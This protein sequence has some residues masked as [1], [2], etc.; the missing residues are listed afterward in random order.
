MPGAT[1]RTSVRATRAV[2]LFAA[3]V[4]APAG[5]EMAGPVKRRKIP[6]RGV[7]DEHHIP[8]A[9]A[10]AAIGPAARDVGL[11]AKAHAAVPAAPPLDLNLCLVV[12][13]RGELTDHWVGWA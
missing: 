13:H 6:A 3:P 1:S 10:V 7:A 5:A 2:A 9:T 8:P 12:E 11:A 4:T